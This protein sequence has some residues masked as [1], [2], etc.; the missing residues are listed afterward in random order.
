[1]SHSSKENYTVQVE[2]GHYT[3]ETGYLSPAR[4][5]TYGL[6][7]A[8]TMRLRPQS[9]LEIGPGPGIVTE[10]LRKI[11]FPV[12]T[13]DL[14]PETFPDYLLS[15]TDPDIDSKVEKINLIIASEIFEHVRY[16]DF[17]A[18]LRNLL[19]MTDYLI[20]TLPNTNDQS[21]AFG[22]RIRLPLLNHISTTFKFR[23][24]HTE[25]TFDGE[26]YWEIGKQGYPAKKVRNDLSS[27]GWKIQSDFINIDNPYH[28]FFILK[29]I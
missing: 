9:I 22:F 23:F 3:S 16:N 18:A 28:H 14:D 8:E 5:S 15:A 17:L 20:L 4:W 13:L 12:K 2:A 21:L 19:K 25:H 26:H 10:T 29:R 7:I 1:M 11:G 24:G 6:I 27:M